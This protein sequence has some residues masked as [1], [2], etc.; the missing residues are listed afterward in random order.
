MRFVK[1]KLAGSNKTCYIQDS[2]IVNF[3]PLTDNC[4]ETKVEL[5]NGSLIIN[6]NV[7]DFFRRL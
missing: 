1:V 5:T 7:E 4:C 2:H 6:E 3:Y